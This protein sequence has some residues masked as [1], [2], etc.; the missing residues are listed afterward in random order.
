MRGD[1]GGMRGDRGGMRGDRGEMRGRERTNVN[2]NIRG[3][4]RYGY[5][6]RGYGYR[7]HRGPRYGVVVPGARCRVVVVRKYYRHRLVVKKIRRCY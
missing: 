6:G 4:E 1:R 2:V 7:Y 5:H 3:G